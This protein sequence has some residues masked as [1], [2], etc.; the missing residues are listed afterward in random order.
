MTGYYSSNEL[1]GLVPEVANSNTM[2]DMFNRTAGRVLVITPTIALAAGAN[3]ANVF[4][5]TGSVRILDQ[6]AEIL[7]ISGG[8]ITNCY[9]TLYDGTNSVNL[10]ADGMDLTGAPV[11]TFF[12]KDQ[13]AAQPY[14]VSIADQCRMLETL[15]DRKTG[16]PF[17]VTQKNGANTYIRFH[18]TAA[19]EAS[20]QIKIQFEYWPINGGA[21]A[22]VL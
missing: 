22:S 16:R 2:A 15:E 14:S 9:A 10:T 12:T 13:V 8:D 18:A 1:G 21:L 20:L 19:A 3:V 4:Q 17:T 11:G 5:V 6:W 7:A